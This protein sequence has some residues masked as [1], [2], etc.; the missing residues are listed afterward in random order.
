MTAYVERY[1][2]REEWLAAV[3]AASQAGT[4]ICVDHTAIGWEVWTHADGLKS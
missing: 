4:L 3:A 1:E 2:S